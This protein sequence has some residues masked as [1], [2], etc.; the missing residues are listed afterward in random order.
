MLDLGL[1]PEVLILS[2]GRLGQHGTDDLVAFESDLF[3]DL[4]FHKLSSWQVFG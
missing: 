3:L 4:F 1:I 2:S